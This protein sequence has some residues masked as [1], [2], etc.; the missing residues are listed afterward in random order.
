MTTR[1][2]TT[3]R[4]S[5]KSTTRSTS[6]KPAAANKTTRKAAP[7]ATDQPV[8]PP[9]VPDLRGPVEKAT[10]SDLEKLGVTDMGLAQSAILMS[11]HADRADTSAAAAQ[12]ARELRM[13]MTNIRAMT[14][15][16]PKK[17]DEPADATVVPR[18]RLEAARRKAA[19]RR[20]RPS[21]K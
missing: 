21:K 6:K 5:A 17:E 7:K 1:K 20:A 11:R 19:G 9:P 8:E 18:S 4:T 13:T 3:P 10:C 15:T 12:A 14:W 2:P 16:P